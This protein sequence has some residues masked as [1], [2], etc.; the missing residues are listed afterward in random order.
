ML[1]RSSQSRRK[2]QAQPRPPLPAN[3]SPKGPCLHEQARAQLDTQAPP[4]PHHRST[5]AL[6]LPRTPLLLVYC[7]RALK[8]PILV[9]PPQ[10]RP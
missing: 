7:R 9:A 8:S 2:P 6:S 1:F 3:P 10:I 5:P 4:P